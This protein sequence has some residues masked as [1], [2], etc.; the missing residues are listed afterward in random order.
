MA[1]NYAF[2]KSGLVGDDA[3][4]SPQETKRL[5]AIVV[6][7]VSESQKTAML[8]CEHQKRKIVTV[9]DIDRGLKY[10]ARNFLFAP[11]T[12]QNVQ[13]MEEMLFDENN[14]D[15]DEEDVNITDDDEWDDVEE[16]TKCSC[17]ICEKI[18]QCHDSW[19]EWNPEDVVGQFIKRTLEQATSQE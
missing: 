13:K 3:G 7:M 2:M 6:S 9:D 10:Q 1:S 19:D 17:E 11:E 15:E 14:Q 12:E 18:R 4:P 16:E 5:L 8:Y